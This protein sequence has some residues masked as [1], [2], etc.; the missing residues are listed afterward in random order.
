MRKGWAAASGTFLFIVAASSVVPTSPSVPE[1]RPPSSPVPSRMPDQTP[2]IVGSSPMPEM[3]SYPPPSVRQGDTKP[4]VPRVAKP[5]PRP[6]RTPASRTVTGNAT[7]YG[8]GYDGL[9]ALPRS[10]GGTGEHVRICSLQTKRCVV[11]TSNDVG[12][13]ERLHRVAD[14][15]APTFNYLCGCQWR[16]LGIMKVRI[17]WL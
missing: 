3:V 6:T 13:V 10:L 17:T 11:R 16:T 9:L 12:P 4:E 5:S 15:D 7:T 1:D 8:D 14:L 2:G